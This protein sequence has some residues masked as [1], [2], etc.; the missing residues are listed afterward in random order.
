ML[1]FQRTLQ[2][3]TWKTERNTDSILMRAPLSSWVIPAKLIDLQKSLLDTWKFF[4]PFLNTLTADDKYSL[5]SRDKWMQTI[6]MHLSKKQNIFSWFFSLFFECA[7]N[8]EHFQKKMTLIAY[9]FLK[10]PTTKQVLR[11]MSKGLV[12]EDPSTGDMQNG[13]KH[14]FNLNRSAFIILSDHCKGN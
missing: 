13:L 12:W 2:Q 9:V 3:A 6:Q 10:L 5:I 4:R 7:L 1:P 11:W 14:W 8:F